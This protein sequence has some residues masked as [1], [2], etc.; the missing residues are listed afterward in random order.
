MVLTIRKMTKATSTKSMM[1][2][3]NVP[4]PSVTASVVS[5]AAFSTMFSLPRSTPPISR[6]TSGMNT[7]F[8]SEVVILPKAPPKI[9]PMAMSSTLPRM[10]NSRNSEKNFFICQFSYIQFV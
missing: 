10:A 6:P 4:M 8:T 5:V 2:D 9:T 7:S 1:V 3:R